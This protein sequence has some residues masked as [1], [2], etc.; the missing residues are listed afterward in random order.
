MDAA[1][2]GN[3]VGKFL[4]NVRSLLDKMRPKPTNDVVEDRVDRNTGVVRDSESV[5]EGDSAVTPRLASR[6]AVLHAADLAV[7]AHQPAQTSD[8]EARSLACTPLR[9]RE[10]GAAGTLWLFGLISMQLDGV[11]HLF[12]GSETRGQVRILHECSAAHG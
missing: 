12:T 11:R 10:S 2:S 7:P 5:V 6:Q 4:H 3:D 9:S 8:P 1:E